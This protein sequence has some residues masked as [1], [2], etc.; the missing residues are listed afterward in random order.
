MDIVKALRLTG[1]GAFYREG[2]FGLSR[3]RQSGDNPE[4]RYLQKVTIASREAGCG[5]CELGAHQ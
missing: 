1:S 2:A 5:V 4:Q 3:A